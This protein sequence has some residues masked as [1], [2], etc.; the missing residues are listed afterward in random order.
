VI[1]I[2]GDHFTA[3]VAEELKYSAAEARA[4]RIKLAG[5]SAS[6][7]ERNAISHE[8]AADDS[9]APRQRVEEAM[10][11]LISKLIEELDLGRRY[12]EATFPA[13]PADRLVFVGGE[14]R[15]RWLCQR[16]AQGLGLVAQLGDP[17]CR[18]SKRCDA[19]IES[20][21]DRR[22]PQPS[23]AV[24]IGLSMGPPSDEQLAAAAAR[25]GADSRS[26]HERA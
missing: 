11:P 20:G 23:W 3:A 1:N 25:G 4:L 8:P 10:A 22:L 7:P 24:A 17:L 12:Y 6:I 14:A 16:I 9:A 5:Q 18:M 21:I 26:T 2:G 19:G 13:R 15:Q